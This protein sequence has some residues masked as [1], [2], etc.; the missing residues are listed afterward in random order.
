MLLA[1]AAKDFFHGRCGSMI[2]GN[3]AAG[4]PP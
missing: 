4:L 1:D 3:D 2:G